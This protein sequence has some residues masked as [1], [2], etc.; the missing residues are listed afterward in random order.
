MPPIPVT[1]PI[2]RSP[3][4]ASINDLRLT[5][6]RMTCSR[7]FMCDGKCVPLTYLCDGIVDC[8]AKEDEENC[9]YIQDLWYKS[10]G[11]LCEICLS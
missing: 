9:Y 5:D 4:N 1:D 2:T 10:D 6:N 3:P 11:N 8:I 7:G